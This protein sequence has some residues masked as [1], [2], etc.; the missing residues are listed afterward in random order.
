MVSDHFNMW[1]G[2]FRMPNFEK[3][4]PNL[5]HL[6]V[7]PSRRLPNQLLVMLEHL[8]DFESDTDSSSSTYQPPCTSLERVIIVTCDIVPL[9]SWFVLR[10]RQLV[11]TDPQ[12]RIALIPHPTDEHWDVYHAWL[13]KMAGRRVWEEVVFW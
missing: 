9:D 12:R 7:P 10:L 3:V 13:D 4:C 6:M 5:T 2:V 11:E 1:R 8:S